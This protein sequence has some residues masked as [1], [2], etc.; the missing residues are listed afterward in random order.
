MSEVL[1]FIGVHKEEEDFFLRCWCIY[2]G[3]LL[4]FLA[5]PKEL[6]G[7]FGFATTLLIAPWIAMIF[8]AGFAKLLTNFHN[9]G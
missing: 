8:T 7:N 1:K 6:L 2:L 5:I 4:V 3:I 9:K